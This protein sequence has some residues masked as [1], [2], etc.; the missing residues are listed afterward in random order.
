M[1]S[2]S[3][4]RPAHPFGALLLGRYQLLSMDACN[5][6][7]HRNV[8][9]KTCPGGGQLVMWKSPALRGPAARWEL[10]GPV[11]TDN[12]TVLKAPAFGLTHHV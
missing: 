3:R 11:W 6:T 8:G 7:S 2:P 12:T 9:G 5:A 4:A 1:V 10:V